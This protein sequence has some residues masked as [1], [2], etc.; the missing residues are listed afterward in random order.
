MR[1]INKH[2]LSLGMRGNYWVVFGE[3][4]VVSRYLSMAARLG[5]ALVGILHGC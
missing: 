2:M 3:L 5:N 1:E 4:S